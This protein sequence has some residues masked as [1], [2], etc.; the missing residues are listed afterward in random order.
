MLTW[1]NRIESGRRRDSRSP[2]PTPHGY[3]KEVSLRR[4]RNNHRAARQ[5]ATVSRRV[6][7]RAARRQGAKRVTHRCARPG[8]ASRGCRSGE[9]DAFSPHFFPCLLSPLS[10][11]SLS[12]SPCRY[13]R[14]F[15]FI[16]SVYSRFLV[17]Y[18]VSS[19]PGLP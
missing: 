14:S 3:R 4:L 17:S 7:S 16:R 13:R 10:C 18:L 12:L 1:R 6:G 8:Q 11:F 19:S 9:E 15:I 2:T 5:S